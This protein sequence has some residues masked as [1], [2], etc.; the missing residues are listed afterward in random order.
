MDEEG[1]G[2]RDEK[3]LR[4]YNVLDMISCLWGFGP[5][6]LAKWQEMFED[7]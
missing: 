7:H 4:I 1:G 2:G 6:I 5:I 3:G